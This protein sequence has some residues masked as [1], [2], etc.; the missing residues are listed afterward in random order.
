MLSTELYLKNRSLIK[1]D[2]TTMKHLPSTQFLPLAAEQ[3]VLIGVTNRLEEILITNI[4]RKAGYIT[5]VVDTL[6]MAQNALLSH[7]FHIVLLDC[8]M[9]DIQNSGF[10]TMI[11]QLLKTQGTPLI[12][13]LLM[14]PNPILSKNLKKIGFHNLLEAPFTEEKILEAISLNKQSMKST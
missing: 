11:P 4:L 10:T 1:A 6:S 12:I 8:Q 3:Y 5:H 13:G 7:P 9:T 2:Q 14:G